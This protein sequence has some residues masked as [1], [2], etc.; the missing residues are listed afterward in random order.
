MDNYKICEFVLSKNPYKDYI[1]STFNELHF[2]IID[3]K[4]NQILN[5]KYRFQSH[6]NLEEN[7]RNYKKYCI[8]MK[9]LAEFQKMEDSKEIVKYIKKYNVGYEFVYTDKNQKE[10]LKLLNINTYFR[11]QFVYLYLNDEIKFNYIKYIF[12]NDFF[13]TFNKMKTKIES[14]KNPVK[15]A[16]KLY[17]IDNNNDDAQD[18]EKYNKNCDGYDTDGDTDTNSDDSDTDK[19]VVS[20]K[21]KVVSKKKKDD[22]DTDSDTDNTDKKVVSKKKKVVSKKKKDDSDTDSDTDNTDKKVVS[23]KKK[24]VSKKKKDDS[25]TDSDTDKKVVSKKKKVVSKKKSTTTKE[26]KAKQVPV[27]YSKI[28]YEFK[29]IEYPK[30]QL[31]YIVFD[32]LQNYKI[33]KLRI[34]QYSA[35]RYAILGDTFL[36]NK[37]LE[38]LGCRKLKIHTERYGFINVYTFPKGKLKNIAKALN[39]DYDE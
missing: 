12:L 37:F 16:M 2:K 9:N 39:I 28:K 24:V 31:K 13:K 4:L 6:S 15:L 19:K 32:D 1:T 30:K 14:S 34:K 22:S 27:D 36:K 35:T 29:K 38:N 18:L 20:K 17:F 5:D 10:I 23:K 3:Y 11:Y 25:D 26:K 33:G 7:K 8:L 21:K